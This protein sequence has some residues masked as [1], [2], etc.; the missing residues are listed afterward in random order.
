[1]PSAHLVCAPSQL[2]LRTIEGNIHYVPASLLSEHSELFATILSLRQTSAQNEDAIDIWESDATFQNFLPL[3]YGEAVTLESTF[4]KLSSLLRL[5]EKWVCPDIIDKIRQS[6][7]LVSFLTELPL[8]SF[9]LSRHFDWSEEAKIASTASLTLDF[10]ECNTVALMDN[11]IENDIEALQALRRTRYHI[12]KQM[13]DSSHRFPT[14]NGYV[15]RFNLP[16]L[17]F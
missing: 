16:Y 4:Q 5:A 10:D 11:M 15:S 17:L 6:P 2:A 13:L 14:G 12:F 7:P 1:M 3:V 8:H 9:A